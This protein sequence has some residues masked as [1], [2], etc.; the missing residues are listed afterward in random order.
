M[1]IMMQIAIMFAICL[2]SQGIVELLPFP[3]PASVMGMVILFLLLLFKVIKLEYIKEKTTFLLQNMAFFFI[4]SG[5]SIMENYD[6]LKGNV[7][8]IFL[9]ALI[10]L[11]LTF[12]ATA[13]TVTF[14]I[15][16]QNRWREKHERIN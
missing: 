12:A 14:V 7:I 1:N 6:L 10:T 9:I 11:I 2:V 13:Y 8:K 4:P 3:F 5:V 15:K 16:L